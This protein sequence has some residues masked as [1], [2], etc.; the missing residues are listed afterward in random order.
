MWID[1]IA[2][3]SATEMSVLL[4]IPKE[5]DLMA[6]DLDHKELKV[7]ISNNTLLP[8]DFDQIPV[9]LTLNISGAKTLSY[10]DTLTGVLNGN[11]EMI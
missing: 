6:C 7:K 10:K 5:E 2:I 3:N 11:T 4:D 1:R 8:I 9:I